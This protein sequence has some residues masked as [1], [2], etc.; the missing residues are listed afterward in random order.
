MMNK[1]IL[2]IFWAVSCLFFVSEKVNAQE[3]K[4]YNFLFIAV[5]D[6]NDWTGFA[7]GH[8]QTQ[9]PNMDLLAASGVVFDKAYCAA[10]VCNPSRSALMTGIRPSSSGVYGNQNY[11]RDS[12]VLKEILTIPEYLTQHGYKTMAKGKIFHSPNGPWANSEVW[13]EYE[14]I[15]GYFG[16][17]VKK[18]GF[19][20]NGIPNGVIDQNLEWGPTDAKLEE[21]SDYQNTQWAAS[22]LQ[23]EHDKPF[24]LACGLTRPHLKWEVPKA[25][26]DKF[27]EEEMIV[28][29]ILESDLDDIPSG[30]HAK[31]K[32]YTGIKKYNKQRSA[33]QAYLANIN[34]ADT[35]IGV[36][37]DALAKSKYAENT[38]V[39]LWG[40]HGWHLGE[41]LHYKKATLWEEATRVPLII[42]VPGMTPVGASCPR[43]VNLMDLY[44]TIVALADIP[45]NESNEGNDITPLLMNPMADW[46]YPSLTTQGE[47]RHSVRDERYRYTRY[48]DGSEELY[49]HSVDSL[50]WINLAD[51]PKYA[52]IKTRL[53]KAMPTENVPEIVRTKN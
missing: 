38:V 46:Q 51:H 34:Y 6:L 33:V 19:M 24:F 12:E 47:N 25:F 26:F 45:K 31:T 2:S 32:N 21:T 23:K 42:K 37:L 44:P 28:P 17:T 8:P 50:E 11:F 10:A 35:C 39:I 53:E 5:D 52:Q 18:D 16:E 3:H 40:D 29:D 30:A 1:Q 15:S 36:V 43:T 7:G 27:P 22:Q 14:K 4:K 9:T 48:D 49:D 41:K 20:A 13:G